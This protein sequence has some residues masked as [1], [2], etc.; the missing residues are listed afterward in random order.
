MN[1]GEV[2]ARV[3]LSAKTIRYYEGLGLVRP[4]RGANGYRAFGETEVHRLAFLGRAR[5][6]GF[7]IEEC[8]ALLTLYDDPGR[9]SADVRRIAAGHLEHVEARIAEL[10]ALRATLADLV[11]SC[12]GDARPNC[13]ILRD[14]ARG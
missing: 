2:A 13:P 3:G 8:R 5:T 10:Q 7:S 1:I 6:L 9:A 12:A 4:R 11:Q 14:L